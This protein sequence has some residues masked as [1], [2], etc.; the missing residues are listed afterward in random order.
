L[1]ISQH[2]AKHN[3]L[4]FWPV[5]YVNLTVGDTGIGID[6]EVIGRIFDPYFTTKL[7]GKGTGLG[8]AVV[9]GIVKDYGGQ[10]SVKSQPE[11]G[12]VFDVYLP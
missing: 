6:Q 10:I 1:Y 4:A 2:Y 12:T 3:T 9:H 7:E 5:S 11:R 8:L